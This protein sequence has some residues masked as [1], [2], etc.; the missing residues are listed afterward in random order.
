MINV[1]KQ[2]AEE[3]M[4]KA[5]AAL[6][7][8]YAAIRTGKASPALLDRITVDYYGVETP[9]NQMA[10][11]S[12][13]E[14]RMLL[15][16]PW[17]KSS[18]AS[19]EKAI[20]KSDLGLTPSNDGAVIRL[21]IPQLTKE[22]RKELAKKVKKLGEDSKVAIRNIRR[23]AN[24]EVKKL[25]KAKEITED[26]SKAAQDAIQKL[27]DKFVAEIDKTAANKETEIM[28]I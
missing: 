12:A 23:D 27:T 18:L 5:I 24:D 2:D 28:E 15:I 14:A 8:E 17:D 3:R 19:I 1:I 7:K 26:D 4:N 6:K 21:V 9:L 22:S 16:Q 20:L 10:G 13:P 11:V 25:E